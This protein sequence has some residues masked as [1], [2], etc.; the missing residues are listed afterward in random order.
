MKIVDSQRPKTAR[1]DSLT[2]PSTFRYNGCI[3]ILLPHNEYIDNYFSNKHVCFCLDEEN[4]C[5]FNKEKD[6]EVQLVELECHV[7]G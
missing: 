6:V 7:K 1:L 2:A 5:H 4:L 3:Y